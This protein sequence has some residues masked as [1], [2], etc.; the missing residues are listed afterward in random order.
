MAKIQ[1]DDW[2]LQLA[3]M[4]EPT[5]LLVD[6]L[7][8]HDI[9]AASRIQLQGTPS[10]SPSGSPSKT[11]TTV[12]SHSSSNPSL[13]SPEHSSK[14]KHNGYKVGG[15][16][17]STGERVQILSYDLDAEGA[18]K[19]MREGVLLKR[20]SLLHGKALTP[21]LQLGLSNTVLPIGI[22]MSKFSTKLYVR[23][24]HT[25]FRSAKDF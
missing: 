19:C 14:Q 23:Q 13:A 15:T 7:P 17:Q 12:L 18:K 24:T 10:S 20:R 2:E 8:D 25:F 21:S 3:I 6:I 5:E 16:C 9:I 4:L 22:W 1:P 11:R